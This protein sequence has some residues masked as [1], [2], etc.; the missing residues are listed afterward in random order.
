M[1]KE[2][3]Y[4]VIA[5][6]GLSLN[7][8]SGKQEIQSWDGTTWQHIVSKLYCIIQIISKISLNALPSSRIQSRARV[9]PKHC[10]SM[11]SRVL[12]N[13]QTSMLLS[14]KG[15]MANI[16][17]GDG[18]LEYMAGLKRQTDKHGGAANTSDISLRSWKT[19]I[20]LNVGLQ[21]FK[22]PSTWL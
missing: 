16:Y 20:W 10:H 19:K 21:L 12:Q 22:G 7:T 4:L 5:N 6:L 11:Y 1:S 3:P 17:M 18:S 8:S 9:F 15:C 13:C 14:S 2:G